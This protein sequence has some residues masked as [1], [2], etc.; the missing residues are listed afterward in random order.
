[1][2]FAEPKADGEN[3]R[4]ERWWDDIDRGIGVLRERDRKCMYEVV[5]KILRNGSVIH[6]TVVV[7]RSTGR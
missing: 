5:S 2:R 6:T 1:V 4:I 3:V 7:A